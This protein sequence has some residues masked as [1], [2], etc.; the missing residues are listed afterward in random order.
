[1]HIGS[2][3]SCESNRLF[4]FLFGC[5]IVLHCALMWSARLYPFVDLP[6]HLGLATVHRHYDD[7]GNHFDNMYAIDLSLKPNTLHLYF[8]SLKIFPSVEFGNKFFFCLYAALFPLSVLFAIRMFGGNP[9]FAFLSFLFLY[10]Y[11]VSYGFVGFTIAVP[12]VIVLFALLPGYVRGYTLLRAMG[13]AVVLVALFFMH[14]LAA[15]FAAFVF[16]VCTACHSHSLRNCIKKIFAVFPLVVLILLWWYN[17][18]RTYEGAGL[19]PLIFDYFK[20]EYIDSLLLRGGLF[21]FDNYALYAGPAGYAVAACFSLSAV[22]MVC[23]GAA[24]LGKRADAE[25]SD[26]CLRIAFLCIACSGLCFLLIPLH[27]PGYSFLIQRFPVFIFLSAVIWGSIPARHYT[28]RALRGLA[29]IAACI[30][31]LCWADYVRDFNRE[32]A[33]FTDEFFASVDNRCIV[34]AFISED[35]F[36]GRPIYRHFVDYVIVWN[37]GI[38]MTRLLDYPFPTALGRKGDLHGLPSFVDRRK[39]NDDSLLAA[40]DYIFVRGEIPER[41]NLLRDCFFIEKAA[42]AW[43]LYKHIER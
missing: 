5:L 12:F 13:C 7:P 35:A 30:H 8:V 39:F 27:L 11:N 43:S 37:R 6:N 28:G 41:F 20:N 42:G 23:C 32:N 15:L 9:W 17:H 1:M 19:L 22:L 16:I 40:I 25:C 29:V 33:G 2:S 18:S 31:F 14:A 38:A 10:N 24:L 34:A 21:I 3:S 26:R 4:Y 36:R